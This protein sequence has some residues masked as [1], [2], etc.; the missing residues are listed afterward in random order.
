MLYIYSYDLLYLGV[1]GL[2]F[3]PKER[4]LSWFI[5]PSL[6]V[7]L[8]EQMSTYIHMIPIK[9]KFTQNRYL[10]ESEIEQQRRLWCHHCIFIQLWQESKISIY[11]GKSKFV[12]LFQYPYKVLLGP[13]TSCT[14]ENSNHCKINLGSNERVLAY[15]MWGCRFKCWFWFIMI[16]M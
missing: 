7:P 14:C 1:M 4:V 16:S 11:A 3:P 12:F 5:Y 6:N 15:S 10:S 2:T 9:F 13:G 8:E